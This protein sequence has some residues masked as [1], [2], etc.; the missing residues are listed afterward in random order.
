MNPISRRSFLKSTVV[1]SNF[2]QKYSGGLVNLERG[3]QVYV[4]R[5]IG[6]SL[7]PVRLNCPP[8]LTLIKLAA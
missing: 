5:G 8:E 6:V 3:T 1:P 4:S 7:I 2:G